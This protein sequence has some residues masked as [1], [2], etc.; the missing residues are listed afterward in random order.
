MSKKSR[1]K[2]RIWLIIAFIVIGYA[3]SQY[4]PESSTVQPQSPETLK[5]K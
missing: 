1:Q 3:A 2:Q 4:S 5:I